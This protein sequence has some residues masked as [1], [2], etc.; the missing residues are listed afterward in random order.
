MAQLM[1]HSLVTIDNITN[2]TLG[3]S[4]LYVHQLYMIKG[5]L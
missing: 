3:S 2:F 5:K 1:K 4:F